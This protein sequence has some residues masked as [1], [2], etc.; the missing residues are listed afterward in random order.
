LIL[1]SR[2]QAPRYHACMLWRWRDHSCRARLRGWRHLSGKKQANHC[3]GE[4]N[5]WGTMVCNSQHLIQ[6]GS[7][8][9]PE[10]APYTPSLERLRR[11]SD[12]IAKRPGQH[13][14]QIDGL[15]LIQ[16]RVP[17]SGQSHRLASCRQEYCISGANH[18]VATSGNRTN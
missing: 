8:L 1:R 4:I 5:G 9:R 11:L 3:H 16:N 13:A 14:D 18:A 15:T 17:E 6:L 12:L 10:E 7:R 2:L